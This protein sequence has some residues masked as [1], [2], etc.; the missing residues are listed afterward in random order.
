VEEIEC[1]AAADESPS[2]CNW[3]LKSVALS[4]GAVGAAGEVVER[5]VGMAE[6]AGRVPF[7]SKRAGGDCSCEDTDFGS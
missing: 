3:L 1:E 6:V 7:D 2:G 5:C 4:L